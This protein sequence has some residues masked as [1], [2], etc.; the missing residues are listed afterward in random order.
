M[1][2]EWRQRD[3]IYVTTSPKASTHS[4]RSG[5]MGSFCNVLPLVTGW[6]LPACGQSG[7]FR[8]LEVSGSFGLMSEEP[9]GDNRGAPKG[10][11]ILSRSRSGRWGS[12]LSRELNGLSESRLEKN[13]THGQ[14]TNNDKQNGVCR[15][16]L[17]IQGCKVEPR[18][19]HSLK[20]KE[21]ITDKCLWIAHIYWLIDWLT[22][23]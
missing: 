18:S 16:L 4:T 7:S 17:Y 20:R 9:V 12:V 5:S 2:K 6:Q 21:T 19:F 23:S 15:V 22:V 1:T 10:R 14:T 8:I 3:V 11:P 13:N